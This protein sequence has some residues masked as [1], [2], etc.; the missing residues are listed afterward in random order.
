MRIADRMSSPPRTIK[1]EAP[2]YDALAAMQAGKLRHLP[3][4]DESGALLG[5]VSESALAVTAS[6]YLDCCI[7]VGEVMERAPMAVTP[8][9]RIEAAAATMVS[10]EVGALPVLEGGALVGVVT[11]EDILGALLERI[12]ALAPDERRNPDASAPFALPPR[13]P[14]SGSGA[15]I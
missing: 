3:V 1:P 8:Q 2:Y 4:V 15:R 14:A 12:E 10:G 9:T 13:A 5:M 6:R 7:E 11:R